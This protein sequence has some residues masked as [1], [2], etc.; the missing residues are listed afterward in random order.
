[1]DGR[2]ADFQ[3]NPAGNNG[4]QVPRIFSFFYEFE[5]IGSS[6]KIQPAKPLVIEPEVFAGHTLHNLLKIIQLRSVLLRLFIAHSIRK[7]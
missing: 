4:I 2:D 5:H 1:M 6:K 3:C 7:L